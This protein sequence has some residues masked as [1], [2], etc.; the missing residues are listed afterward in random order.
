[1]G[2]LK[3]RLA[4]LEVSCDERVAGE[5]YERDLR[6]RRTIT[7]LVIAEHARI[8]KLA[9]GEGGDLV[10]KA[11]LAVAFDQYEDLGEEHREYI[12][13]GWAEQMRDWSGIDWGVTTGKLSPPPGWE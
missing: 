13:R 8:A 7:R 6:V 3:K 4:D 9:S 2:S 1:M 5:E 10:E 12:G 11:C